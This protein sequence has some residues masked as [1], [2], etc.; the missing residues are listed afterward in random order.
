MS[1]ELKRAKVI[2][3]EFFKGVSGLRFTKKEEFNTVIDAIIDAAIIEQNPQITEAQIIE[4]DWKEAFY[5]LSL[6]VVQDKTDEAK[7]LI[8]KV[9]NRPEIKIK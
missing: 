2:F 7:E 9:S 5:Q 4:P 1:S 6:L 8:S 3:Y